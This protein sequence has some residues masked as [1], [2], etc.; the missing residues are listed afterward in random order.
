MATKLCFLDVE[1]TGLDAKKHGII[2]LAM[3]MECKPRNTSDHICYCK[4]MPDD[5]IEPLALE[6]NGITLEELA[7]DKH[8]PPIDAYVRFCQVLEG[9]VFKFDKKDKLL[10]VGYN[11]RFD[12]DFLRAWFN[13]CDP[14]EG[15]YFGSYF[16]KIPLDVMNLCIWHFRD[17]L[18]EFPNFKLTTMASALGITVD[19]ERLHDAHYDVELTAKMYHLLTKEN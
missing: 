3:I 6:I 16:H 19:E 17:R 7:S 9:Y 12:M 10:L 1:T 5:I 13:K 2:Q 4:P 15:K 18:H 11:A 8:I 14:K